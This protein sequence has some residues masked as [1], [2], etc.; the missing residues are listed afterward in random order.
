MVFLVLPMISAAVSG[1]SLEAN[2]KKILFHVLPM[3]ISSKSGETERRLAKVWNAG[4]M[5]I[6]AERACSKRRAMPGMT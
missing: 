4:I 5:Q 2:L 1:E 3:M 6:F